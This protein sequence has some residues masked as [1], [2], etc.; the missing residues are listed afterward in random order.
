MEVILLQDVDTLGQAND[1]VKVKAGYA[2]NYLMPRKLA[3]E[4]NDH[5]R[6]LL[7]ERQKQQAIKEEKMVAE[8]SKISEQLQSITLRIG[9]KTGTSGKIFGSVTT[10]QIA[11]ALKNQASFSIDRKKIKLPEDEIKTIGNY[12]VTIDLGKDATVPVQIEVVG[13]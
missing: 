6:K 4:A 5:Q 7:V 9:A 10:M 13:E 1:M 2:R 3:I 11:Q 8:I 12:T